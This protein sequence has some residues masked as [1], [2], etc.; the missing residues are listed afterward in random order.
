VAQHRGMEFLG[1]SPE[2]LIRTVV[3]GALAYVALVAMLRV[4]GKRTLSQMNAFDFVVTV[5]LG[6]TLATILLSNEVSLAQGLTALALLI[7]LQ[8]LIT[9]TSVRSRTTSRLVKSEPTAVVWR[10][11]MLHATMARERLLE[12]EVD[13]AVREHGLPAAEAADLVILETD[14]T[15]SV[16]ADVDAGA[17]NSRR[18]RS[19]APDEAARP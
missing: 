10:G 7:G 9:W 16:V 6:S 19:L 13:A 5:A 1:A 3:V 17:W 8:F 18:L 14:G 2:T 11:Q 15:I 4:S 12:A